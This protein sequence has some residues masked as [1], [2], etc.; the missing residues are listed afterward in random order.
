MA[1]VT[2]MERAAFSRVAEAFAERVA[3]SD[4]PV[5]RGMDASRI[6]VVA[7]VLADEAAMAWLPAE[8][9]KAP[10]PDG[11]A[12]LR[13]LRRA[14]RDLKTGCLVWTGGRYAKSTYG[15]IV[16]K[17]QKH[18][19]HRL[20][21]IAQRGEIPK[22]LLVCH[23]CD[24]PACIAIEHLFLGTAKDNMADMRRKG[25]GRYRSKLSLEEVV[26]VKRLLAD[27]MTMASVARETGVAYAS[28]FAIKSGKNWRGV[29]AR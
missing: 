9:D 29:A 26:R 28:V 11:E 16:Y 19:A 2:G 8:T 7:L 18:R 23:A 13:L 17:G 24:N 22:G 1:G 12:V 5:A 10:A 27:G 4:A 14:R 20:S 15:A 6:P 21:W 3:C 25:R